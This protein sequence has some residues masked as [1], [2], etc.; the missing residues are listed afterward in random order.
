MVTDQWHRQV[1]KTLVWDRESAGR[2]RG[3]RGGRPKRPA[4]ATEPG[5]RVGAGPAA[6][7]AA[8]AGAE[9]RSRG[10]GSSSAGRGGGRAGVGPRGGGDDRG[11]GAGP[12]GT[13]GGGAR[14]DG[15]G[16]RGGAEAAATA[17]AGA[18]RCGVSGDGP[19]LWD[20]LR[21]GYRLWRERGRP[22][23]WDFGMTVTEHTQR[24]WA[25]SPDHGPYAG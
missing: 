9:R 11:G 7:A 8:G 5:R 4:A 3:R 15:R 13:A 6:A 16:D 17:T 10:A 21:P 25:G 23:Q 2:P 20:A 1:T 12:P 22:L 14:P 24:V 19:G 18:R